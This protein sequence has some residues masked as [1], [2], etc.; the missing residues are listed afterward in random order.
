MKKMIFTALLAG[1]AQTITAQKSNYGEQNRSYPESNHINYT[2]YS[3]EYHEGKKRLDEFVKLNN[4]VLVNQNETK[5]SYHYEFVID[6]KYVVL[7]DSICSTIGYVSSKNLNSYNNTERLSEAR[8]ELERLENKKFEFDKM[9][10]R[11]DSVKSDRYYNHWELIR[12]IDAQIYASKKWIGQLEQIKNQY[13]VKIDLNDE[14]SSP[15]NSKVNFVHMPGVE[16]VYLFPESPLAGLSYN[17][18]QGVNLKYL[19]TKGKSYFGLGALKAVKPNLSDSTA[20]SELFTFTFGQDWYSR[21][22]GRGGNKFFNLYIGYQTGISLAYNDFTSR[23]LPFISP[24]TGIELFKNKYILLD[25]N[26]NY[27]LPMANENRNLR[28]WRVGGSLN[29]SF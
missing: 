16:Y 27:Y 7:I 8:L 9:L 14:Q 17:A 13:S 1:F 24:S 3:V 21:H 28:G 18:Y 25:V 22:L 20:Y 19:F 4:F 11:I 26:V 6:Q 29:F 5:D 23:T 10:N 12:D 15:S 2:I